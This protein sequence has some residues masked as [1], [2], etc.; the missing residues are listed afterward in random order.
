MPLWRE[1]AADLIPF[2][3]SIDVGMH[4]NLTEGAAL[5][6]AWQACYGQAFSS[7]GVMLGRSLVRQLDKQVVAAEFEAQLDAFEAAM[8]GVPRFID[9]HQHVHQ[10]AVIRD[11]VLSVYEKRLRDKGVYLRLA[12]PSV[13]SVKHA[14]RLVIVLSGAW[15]FKRR[16]EREGIPHNASF[17]GSYDFNDLGRYRAHFQAFLAEIGDGGLIMCHPAL[18][19]ANSQDLIAKARF[20]EYLYFTSEQFLEDCVAKGVKIGQ[21]KPSVTA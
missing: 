4:F 14:K 17:S 12:L 5:S 7:L 13:S 21:Y 20:E 8:G 1:A 11:A 16:L 19:A 9:G 18:N 3:T 2:S 6:S 10:F 15:A